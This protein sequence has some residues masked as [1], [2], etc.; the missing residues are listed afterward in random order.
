MKQL[1]RISGYPAILVFLLAGASITIVGFA[2]YNLL[3]MGMAN[4]R[5]IG[6]H[7]WLALRT[8]AFV[9]LLQLLLYGAVALFFFILFKI[10]ESELVI[11]YRRW[12]DR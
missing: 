3:Q 4:L 12:M 6:E 7:G 5:F 2:T 10:C 11:R 9:Q 8:G 1:I